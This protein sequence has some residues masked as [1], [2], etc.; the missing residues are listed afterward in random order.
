M[1]TAQPY[2][3]TRPNGE[4]VWVGKG[5]S[6]KKKLNTPTCQWC[7]FFG[8]SIEMDLVYDTTKPSGVLKSTDLGKRRGDQN[9]QAGGRCPGLH[10]KDW[11]LLRSC[12]CGCG[13]V[14]FMSNSGGRNVT[15]D[16]RESRA[17][18]AALYGDP[19]DGPHRL[20]DPQCKARLEKEGGERPPFPGWPDLG[21][22]GPG[23]G[24]ATGGGQTTA[25]A[26]AVATQGGGTAAAAAVAPAAPVV[27]AAQGGGVGGM[28]PRTG[29]PGSVS[30]SPGTAT[31]LRRG[32]GAAAAA[33]DDLAAAVVA[34][35]RRARQEVEQE[36]QGALAAAME[37][38][39]QEK[40]A[41]LAAAMEQ[42]QQ[43]KQ[44]ALTAAEQ[45]K[46]D[47]IV[48][49]DQARGE[50]QQ[51]QSRLRGLEGHTDWQEA[52]RKLL[53]QVS[54]TERREQGLREQLKRAQEE[55]DGGKT[56]Q[57]QNFM[58]IQKH[59]TEIEQLQGNLRAAGQERDA[60]K[61]EV[62]RLEKE[63]EV[64]RRAAESSSSD[65]GEDF[66]KELQKKNNELQDQ[67][68]QIEEAN[69]HLRG[70]VKTLE[71]EIG[72]LKKAAACQDSLYQGRVKGLQQEI[73]DL[74]AQLGSPPT[75]AP[76][77]PTPGDNE[78]TGTN[79]SDEFDAAD[80]SGSQL[81]PRARP[82]P[83]SMEDMSDSGIDAQTAQDEEGHAQQS[84]ERVVAKVRCPTCRTECSRSRTSEVRV[85]GL[86]T[87]VVCLDEIE[88]PLR[89]FANCSHFLCM[90]Q[91][92]LDACRPPGT[93]LPSE[94]TEESAA[95]TAE[96]Q[97]QDE[98]YATALQADAETDLQTQQLPTEEMRRA[99]INR[100]Q[101]GDSLLAAGP[102]D[103]SS[104]PDRGTQVTCRDIGT[105][106]GEDSSIKRCQKTLWDYVRKPVFTSGR[107]RTL[108]LPP[109][110]DVFKLAV[111]AKIL[112][113]KTPERTIADDCQDLLLELEESIDESTEV[114]VD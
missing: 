71:A 37:Q 44:A 54:Q 30:L 49:R 105:Q 31:E 96:R 26:V 5:K 68:P 76:S 36:K 94:T 59:Q 63:L 67:L 86:Q 16:L 10:E 34:A 85:A 27:P 18:Y 8:S 22:G 17:A 99:R 57:T 32:G 90:K 2:G 93:E 84:L 6:G 48:E 14:L 50:V 4:I 21:E 7:F 72:T 11:D 74:K 73:I 64:C 111:D 25:A 78:E 106:T 46:D 69:E 70:Q 20:L 77:S 55:V 91:S 101:D 62:A 60:A 23:S 100:F 107:K 102:G 9:T 24:Q 35:D 29:A 66:E 28:T 52:R 33:P 92:C 65:D 87:C 114:A 40:R 89:K 41:A 108:A 43:E 109:K 15:G 110:F 103:T 104:P 61:E 112:D 58:L 12:V 95:F 47:V 81:P 113:V 1:S 75:V 82:P 45:E 83:G 79:L 53:A 42:A 51:L 80:V 39:E 98:E 56:L 13:K 3:Y 97:Q 88:S 38:A 19:G